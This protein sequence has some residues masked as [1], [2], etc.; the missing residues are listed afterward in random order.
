MY[1]AEIEV[2]G[3]TIISSVFTDGQISDLALM[4]DQAGY[5][6]DNFRRDSNLFA[7]RNLIGE[8]PELQQVLWNDKFNY[9][10]DNLFGEHYFLTKAIYF[11][12][13]AMSNWLVSW[14]Q[15]TKIS[16]DSRKEIEGF[17]QWTLKQGLQS[18]Q[19]SKE[20]LEDIYTIRIHLDDCDFANGALKVIPR[21]HKL[22]ILKDEEILKLDKNESICEVTRGG[23][24]IMKPL[25]VHSSSKSTSVRNRRA[26]HLEF[27]S[28]QLPNGL[29]WREMV[30]RR[31]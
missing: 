28:K 29:H 6:N 2:D 27:A 3:F 19:P 15:D 4:I 10:I 12:K 22:G 31:S 26:I 23:I 14:H 25:L 18:V 7:I 9:L 11:D 20:Y 5:L 24:M 16:V 17:G 21:S 13:S 30:E 8:I 1:K